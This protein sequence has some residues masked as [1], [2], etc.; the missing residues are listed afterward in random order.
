MAL[1]NCANKHWH[2][3]QLAGPNGE[4]N[5]QESTIMRC[6]SLYLWWYC[7]L[8]LVDGQMQPVAEAD[9][10][11]G[12]LIS[13]VCELDRLFRFNN[14][15]TYFGDR[16]RNLNSIQK[17]LMETFHRPVIVGGPGIGRLSVAYECN[18][19]LVVFNGIYDPLLNWL[20]NSVAN[21]T[22]IQFMFVYKIMDNLL[23][24]M[25]FIEAFFKWC[26]E[27]QM[28]RAY[29]FYEY[30]NTYD[31]WMYIMKPD[32]SIH[33]ITVEKLRKFPK[34]IFYKVIDVRKTVSFVVFYPTFPDL[35]TVSPAWP[36]LR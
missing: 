5:S 7:I 21:N 15:I 18:L 17:S 23:P 35:F 9:E 30:K 24:G 27:R 16:E 4:R 1:N 3:W 36:T 22:R 11:N 2:R 13:I 20:D 33:K 25:S 26:W 28:F 32:M 6:A 10:D 19:M 14:Y 31:L 29:L 12:I 8:A 34:E